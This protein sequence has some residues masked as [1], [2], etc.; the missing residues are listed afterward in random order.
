MCFKFKVKESKRF[1]L[2]AQDEIYRPNFEGQLGIRRNAD[3]KTSIKLGGESMHIR[4]V[5]G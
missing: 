1:A 4:I 2:V 5:V 3:D